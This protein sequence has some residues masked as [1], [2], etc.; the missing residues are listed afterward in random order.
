MEPNFLEKLMQSIEKRHGKDASD[1]IYYIVFWIAIICGVLFILD[2]V[3]IPFYLHLSRMGV[4]IELLSFLVQI[5]SV[6]ML[7]F[8]L[9]IVWKSKRL[10]KKIERLSKERMEE[11]DQYQE[12]I[13]NQTKK[14]FQE[15]DRVLAEAKKHIKGAEE[16]IKNL[17]K[18][19]KDED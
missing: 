9:Y 15:S 12:K 3:G 7:L 10:Q 16:V 8:G 18:Q 4:E 1:F 2:K 5:A 14:N 19:S 13:Y 17:K 6:A 11:I